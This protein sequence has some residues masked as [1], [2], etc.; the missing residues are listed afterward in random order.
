MGA[1]T[2]EQIDSQLASLTY[3]ATPAVLRFNDSVVLLESEEEL[4]TCVCHLKEYYAKLRVLPYR[5]PVIH[6]LEEIVH[7][8]EEGVYYLVHPTKNLHA[9]DAVVCQGSEKYAESVVYRNSDST[10]RWCKTRIY[11]LDEFQSVVKYSRDMKG[12]TEYVSS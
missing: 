10:R 7:S 6:P 12:S 1:V 4:T 9:Q 3:S 11:D 2:P 5:K 8:L